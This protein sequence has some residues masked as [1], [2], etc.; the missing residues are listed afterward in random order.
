MATPSVKPGSRV[1]STTKSFR[2]NSSTEHR[3]AAIQ[4]NVALETYGFSI[5]AMPTQEFLDRFLPRSGP[6]NR[7][8]RKN[9][10]ENVKPS[11]A[12]S[13][14]SEP[15]EFAMYDPFVSLFLPFISFNTLT[16]ARSRS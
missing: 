13:K 8:V 16:M 14:T 3:A 1:Y 12:G 5:G 7:K 11:P 6:S 4:A 2:K 9:T 10:F 15:G